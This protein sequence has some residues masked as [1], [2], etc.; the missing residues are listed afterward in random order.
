[1]AIGPGVYF[2]QYVNYSFD[3][4]ERELE[5]LQK[6][7]KSWKLKKIR[8]KEIKE[9]IDNDCIENVRTQI[10]V[11]KEL[12]NINNV[13][14]PVPEQK[15]YIER[16]SVLLDIPI[17][18]T[19]LKSRRIEEIK[20]TFYCNPIRGGKSIIVGDDGSYLL[21]TSSAIS[22]EKLKEVF[23]KGK[24]N[25]DFNTEDVI[26]LKDIVTV[27]KEERIN[28]NLIEKLHNLSNAII[29]ENKLD[30]FWTDTARNILEIIVLTNLITKNDCTKSELETQ[31]KDTN[32]IKTMINEN[33]EKLSIPELKGIMLSKTIIDS[34]KPF[35]SIMDII[36][37]EIE[38]LI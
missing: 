29:T 32:Y 37:K 24:R 28:Q 8:L 12:L 14:Q 35:E 23:I 22:F 16:I 17:T 31:V 33:F 21:T 5:K 18:N 34:E 13:E 19:E 20:A 2:D 9:G 36:R 1:M 25:G 6:E 10:N 3:E 38:K 27:Y 26:S 15:K 4:L 11:I 7:L 30:P